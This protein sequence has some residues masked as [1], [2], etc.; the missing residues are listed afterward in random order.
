MTF[1]GLSS[2]ATTIGILFSARKRRDRA[3]EDL[4]ETR[5]RDFRGVR[6]LGV[7]PRA[8]AGFAAPLRRRH[9]FAHRADQ[10]RAIRHDLAQGVPGDDPIGVHARDAGNGVSPRFE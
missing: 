10:A 9:P 5:D 4:R 8:Q 2:V 3:R 6:L 1:R 7:S